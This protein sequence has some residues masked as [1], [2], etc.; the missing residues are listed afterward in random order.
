MT[1]FT[2]G[3]VHYKT[4]SMRSCFSIFIA[5]FLVGCITSSKN[6]PP[7]TSPAEKAFYKAEDAYDAS[8]YAEAI[9]R[10]SRIKRRYPYSQYAALADLRIAD[11]YF[12][13]DSFPSAVEQYRGFRKLHPNH[14]KVTYASWRIAE[15]YYQDL[16][17]TFF[18][19]PPI[20]ERELS[21][22]K[23]AEREFRLF[24]KRFP[25]SDYT[26][27]A[28]SRL[29][30]VRRI[31]ADHEYYVATFY[32]KNDNPRGAA[33]RLTELLTN[34]SGLGLDP[35]ALFL[36]GKCY[37]ELKDVGAAKTA[38]EDLI[39]AFP[40]HELAK[41]AAAYLRDHRLMGKK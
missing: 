31:L 14:P 18:L 15:A 23:S 38:L 2:P 9:N 16:P 4:A 5:L 39:R 33:M 19:Y 35:P 28:T 10:Y 8:E 13:Q 26:A 12:A 41:D 37:L 34:Y 7:A 17:T 32:L 40:N 22:S 27:K 21:R 11:A 20:Y 6:R 29:K 30:Q 36:L 3:R 1:R 25:E 24:L